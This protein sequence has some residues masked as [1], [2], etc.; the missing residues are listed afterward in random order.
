LYKAPVLRLPEDSM[1]VPISIVMTT[2]NQERYLSA[3]I[4]SILAQTR[5]D[6]ELLVWDDGST[7]G[8]VEVALDQVREILQDI[9]EA[10]GVKPAL[11]YVSFVPQTVAP[12][13]TQEGKSL[14]PQSDSLQQL[15]PQGVTGVSGTSTPPGA[16]QSDRKF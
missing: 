11:I 14:S 8:S 12:E 9:E 13:A 16:K 2:Y 7:D 3:A 5:R 15:S 4:A 1:A 6:F 10:T